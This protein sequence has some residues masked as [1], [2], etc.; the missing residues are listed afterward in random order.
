[1]GPNLVLSLTEYDRPKPCMSYNF[2]RRSIVFHQFTS[3]IKTRKSFY[4]V[5]TKVIS[6][7]F[8][9]ISVIIQNFNYFSLTYLKIALK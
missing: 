4:F 5:C 2:V 8:L 6:D 9:S 7:N 1:M 3:N